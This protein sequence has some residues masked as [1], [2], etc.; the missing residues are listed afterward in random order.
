[1]YIQCIPTS[2]HNPYMS[3]KRLPIN[4][5]LSGKSLTWT[6]FLQSP[7]NTTSMSKAPVLMTRKPLSLYPLNTHNRTDFSE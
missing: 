6:R 4:F 3:E 2:L 5:N 1:M 7:N